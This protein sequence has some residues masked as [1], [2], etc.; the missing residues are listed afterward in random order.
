MHRSASG[1]DL[2]MKV[3]D[4]VEAGLPAA[5]FDYGPC[6]SELVPPELK[7]LMFTDAQELADRLAMLMLGTKLADLHTLMAQASG[8]LWSEE[9]RRVALPAI[10]D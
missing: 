1:V 4:M 9:W 2:P 7:P 5:V 3:V 8:P 10:A 6:L